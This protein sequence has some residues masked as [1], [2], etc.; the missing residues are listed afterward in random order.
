MCDIWEISLKG[1]DKSFFLLPPPSYLTAGI[2]PSVPAVI[3]DP[4]VPTFEVKPHA[5]ELRDR[6]AGFLIIPALGHPR[7]KFLVEIYLQSIYLD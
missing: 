2:I 4:Q 1:R 7:Q 5:V 6:A 3:L